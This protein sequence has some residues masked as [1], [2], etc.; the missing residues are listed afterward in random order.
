MSHDYKQDS[1]IAQDSDSTRGDQT[2]PERWTMTQAFYANM[3]GFVI[4]TKPLDGKEYIPGSPRLTFTPRG[5]LFL[6]L[7]D[8]LPNEAESFINDKSKA[9]SFAKVI[10]CMQGGWLVIQ[11]IARLAYQLPITLLEINTIGHVLCA[12]AMYIFWF[13]KPLDINEPTVVSS[14]KFENIG[15]V[16][17]LMWMNSAVSS[18]AMEMRSGTIEKDTEL[19]SLLFHDL[20][21][22]E[23][24]GRLLPSPTIVSPS[25]EKTKFGIS[26]GQILNGT[27]FTL[28]PRSLRFSK[29]KITKAEQS[30]I[31][32]D[33]VESGAGEQM[34]L[35]VDDTDIQRW[36][37]ASQVLQANP[38][39]LSDSYFKKIAPQPPITFKSWK[40]KDL[41][42][43][44][45]RDYPLHELGGGGFYIFVFLPLATALYGG[46]HSAAWN[47]YFP[48]PAERDLWR[49]SS[50]IAASS[51]PM[52]SIVLTLWGTLASVGVVLDGLAYMSIGI[53][54]LAFSASQIFLVIEAFISLREL[55]LAAYDT[56]RW[57]QVIPHI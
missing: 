31:K 42:C 49:Y 34:F 5:I 37:M 19:E 43:E 10:T 3:G 15:R 52:F 39:L 8:I 41:V 32:S 2:S 47:E 24:S 9:N 26:E 28:N 44:R 20:S 29:N 17:A 51:G 48:T 22:G 55:P 21:A 35:E 46:L 53:V 13:S 57:L 4:D 45:R 25:E 38:T 11:C 54:I 23:S 16:C 33:S 30:Q 56:P 14:D 27:G 18:A 12:F 1:Q 6:A 50:I 36:R 40:F 7:N